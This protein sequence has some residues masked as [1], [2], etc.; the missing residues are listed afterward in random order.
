MVVYKCKN[1][2]KIRVKIHHFLYGCTCITKVDRDVC[3]S[4]FEVK[5]TV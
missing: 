3:S 5:T 4:I 2:L 1:K